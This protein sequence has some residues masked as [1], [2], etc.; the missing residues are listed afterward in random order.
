MWEGR[1]SADG[2]SAASRPPQA[3]RAPGGH[4][5]GKRGAA[6]SICLGLGLVAACIQRPYTKLSS[7]QAALDGETGAVAAVPKKRGRPAKKTVLEVAS[8]EDAE[9]PLPNA[10]AKA[11]AKSKA[12]ADD[13][14]S[15]AETWSLL[16]PDLEEEAK[17]K[18]GASAQEEAA[19]AEAALA[20]AAVLDPDREEEVPMRLP[21][22]PSGPKP[23]TRRLIPDVPP[24]PPPPVLLP[25]MTKKPS[26]AV[27]L[28]TEQEVARTD[29]LPPWSRNARRRAAA[30]PSEDGGEQ[31][32]ERAASQEP[33]AP[34]PPWRR[35]PAGPSTP[36]PLAPEVLVAAPAPSSPLRLSHSLGIGAVEVL[37]VATDAAL[38]AGELLLQEP[39]RDGSK[40][41]LASAEAKLQ[42]VFRASFPSPSLGQT[43]EAGEDSWTWA[44]DSMTQDSDAR[45]TS[46]VCHTPVVTI[47]AYAKS[48]ESEQV[49]VVYDPFRDELFTAIRGRGAELNGRELKVSP[50][51]AGLQ[52]AT[53]AA[54]QTSDFR[55]ARPCLRALYTLT[56]PI[57]H[58]LRMLGSAS[59]SLAWVA[60]GRLDAFFCLGAEDVK[61]SLS[62]GA[63]IAE[64]AGGFVTDCEGA[65]PGHQHGL[66]TGPVCASAGGAVHQELIKALQ[67]CGAMKPDVAE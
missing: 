10:K 1:W 30:A 58:Q 62:A 61:W 3:L 52:F 6:G 26:A 40:R 12:K 50:A 57:A 48:S 67:R 8:S 15:A 59:Q 45:P 24:Q 13:A 36:K 20:P 33:A 51:A 14:E 9:K 44:W 56:P 53:V 66:I 19:Q 17:S 2:G 41:L 65:R 11:K 54:E 38:A 34:P 32:A 7:R 31:K 21:S 4:T 49:A 39:D 5:S 64:E 25:S 16:F 63:L 47:F 29:T 43:S 18:A 22:L 35:P 42:E 37:A 60:S 27:T 46:L 23:Y 55:S 28:D